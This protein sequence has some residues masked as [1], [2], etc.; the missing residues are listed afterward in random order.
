MSDD[1]TPI[2]HTEQLAPRPSAS[3]VPMLS[4]EQIALLQQYAEERY[5]QIEIAEKIGASVGVVSRYCK[6]F[7]LNVRLGAA[8]PDVRPAIAPANGNGAVPAPTEQEH[9][10]GYMGPPRMATRGDDLPQTS[11][12]NAPQTSTQTPEAPPAPRRRGRPRKQQPEP[13]PYA[14]DPRQMALPETGAPITPVNILQPSPVQTGNATSTMPSATVLG[15]TASRVDLVVTDPTPLEFIGMVTLEAMRQRL[16]PDEYIA[17]LRA[18]VEAWDR[19]CQ[20][21]HAG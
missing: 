16:S 8:A 7:G 5:T 14:V 20:E 6:R 4:N 19:A 17:R 18:Q 9:K 21:L 12:Q 2:I 10:Q 13:V 3:R 11:P 15:A 1:D